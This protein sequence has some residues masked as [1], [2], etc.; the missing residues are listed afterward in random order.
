VKLRESSLKQGKFPDE[1]RNILVYYECFPTVSPTEQ[2]NRLNYHISA[3]AFTNH[4]VPWL[5]KVFLI[6]SQKQCCVLSYDLCAVVRSPSTA[7]SMF[8]NT[9][10]FNLLT[11]QFTYVACNL[12]A[13]DSY[14]GTV[15]FIYCLLA[16]AKLADFIWNGV[17]ICVEMILLCLVH[18]FFLVA[19][20]TKP[21][22]Y[23]VLGHR[24]NGLVGRS[25]GVIAGMVD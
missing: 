15:S 17:C 4:V 24:I 25:W 2:L 22:Q 18:S 13:V 23:C 5:V 6:H 14:H 21:L 16:V 8:P 11:I 19:C 10:K 12:T 1:G 9:V 7:G 20:Y 3:I